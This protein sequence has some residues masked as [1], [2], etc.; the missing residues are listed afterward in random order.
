[1]SYFPE[2]HTHSKKKIEFELD[3]ST[4]AKKCDLKNVTGA[5][6]SDFTKK[7]DLANL[8]SDVDKIDVDKLKNVPSS[9]GS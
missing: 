9:L 4:Y 6:T 7:I 5:D 8:K 2:P 3:L 1:M